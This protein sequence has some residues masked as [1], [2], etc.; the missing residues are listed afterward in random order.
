MTTGQYATDRR[1]SFRSLSGG[2]A[3]VEG[4]VSYRMTRTRITR[5]GRRNFTLDELL[6][7]WGEIRGANERTASNPEAVGVSDIDLESNN[8]IE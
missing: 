2:R 1:R 4:G 6:K 3:G 7:E 8:I 5:R